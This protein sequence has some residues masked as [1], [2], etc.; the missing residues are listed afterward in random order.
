MSRWSRPPEFF[1]GAGSHY[2]IRHLEK[3]W[4]GDDGILYLEGFILGRD[5][6][7]EAPCMLH[8]SEQ[9]VVLFYYEVMYRKIYIY[10]VSCT[11]YCVYIVY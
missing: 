1:L 6:F 3:F 5:D 4:A 8:L 9:F 2:D 7:G 10:S 11:M